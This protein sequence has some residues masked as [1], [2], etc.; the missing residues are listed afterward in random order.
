MD[1]QNNNAFPVKITFGFSIQHAISSNVHQDIIRIQGQNN[2][3]IVII[4][5]KPVLLNVLVI[6]QVNTIVI[7]VLSQKIELN[8]MVNVFVTKIIK[9][10]E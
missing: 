2:A 3:K 5:A 1:H 6:F 4:A 8:K 7:I 10:M 9:M